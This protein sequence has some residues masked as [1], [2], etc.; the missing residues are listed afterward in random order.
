MAMSLYFLV[1][2]AAAFHQ[3]IVP[4]LAEAWRRRN[5][6]PCRPLV[7]ALLPAAEAFAQRYYTDLEGSMLVRLP[8]GLPFN[9]A[10]WRHFVGEVLLYAA[11]DIPEI[12]T[13]PETLSCLLTPKRCRDGPVQRSMFGPVEQAHF[14]S[15]DLVFGSGYYRPEQ[16]GWNDLDDVARLAAYLEAVD[17]TVWTA[18]DLA[19]LPGLK[20]EEDC[21]EELAYVR[22]WLPALQTLYR[23]AHERQE[24]IICE[25]IQAAGP[26]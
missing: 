5:F 14:G 25:T 20:E 16:A 7:A 8:H 22:D 10:V 17:P 2:D 9:R 12:E 23:Q 11:R 21:A 6:A 18:A 26:A 1:H 4:A 15:R 13:A 3:Q 19:G 24:V